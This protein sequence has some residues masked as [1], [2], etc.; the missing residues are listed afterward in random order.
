MPSHQSV[1]PFTIRQDYAMKRSLLALAAATTTVAATAQDF[2]VRIEP[3]T[4]APYLHGRVIVP[5]SPLKYQNIFVGG[6]DEVQTTATNGVPAG[7]AKAKQWHDFL[8]FTPSTE[9]GNVL[10][11]VTVNHEM[12]QKNDSIGDGGGMTMFKIGK[13]ADGTIEVL[14]QILPDGR[15]GKFFNVDFAN[16]VGETGMNCGGINAPSGRIWTAEEWY[17]TSN[18]QIAEGFSDTTEF[19][20]G[21]KVPSGFAGLD[22]KKIKRYENLNWMVEI[23]PR[24]AKA[25][26]KQYNWSR[27]GFEAGV[28]MP[29]DK[30]VYLFED[31][32]AGKSILTKFVADVAGDF[33]K[34]K[35]YFYKQNQGQF[36]GTWVEVPNNPATDWAILSAP[37]EW[38]KTQGITGFTRLEWGAYNATDGRIYITETGND[39]PGARYA[40]AITEGWTLPKHTYDRATAQGTTIDNS[41]YWDYYGRVLVFDP[42][43]NSVRS[44]IEGGPFIETNDA[45]PANYPAKHLSNPDGLNFL[46]VNGKTFMVIEEDLNG[47]SMGRMPNTGIN[48]T[49]CEAWLLDMSKEP[50]IDNLYR[51]A[52]SPL[53]SEITGIISVDDGNTVLINSQHPGNLNVAPFNNS[54]TFAVS[55]LKQV[56][57]SIDNDDQDEEST[58]IRVYPNPTSSELRFSVAT[59][60]ALYDATG[61]RL[62]VVRGSDMMDI[63]DLASG[64]YYVRFADGSTQSVVVTK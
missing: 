30:T 36:T 47:V 11:Y 13:K 23:D 5:P 52:I 31:G 48:S 9:G 27:Q 57:S 8:G 60:A 29:D 50:T 26:R 18:R 25:V 64:T 14:D 62:R 1:T 41:A 59:D 58:G 39:K 32:D 49:N 33:T 20:I 2:P 12:V 15:T 44:F 24:T 16:T 34:G 17:Q 10:G 61:A 53:G 43:D 28:V 4:M 46:Y 22:G 51:L 37:H 54:L 45:T 38:A 7:K 35:L 55:G 6:I 3:V 21:S 56:I 42:A 19:T 40:Q 63:R